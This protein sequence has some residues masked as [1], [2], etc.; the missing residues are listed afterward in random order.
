MRRT[1]ERVQ[2]R[3][4]ANH[5][6]IQCQRLGCDHTVERVT[7]LPNET[8]GAECRFGIDRQQGVSSGIHIVEEFTFELFRERKLTKTYLRCDFPRRGCRD[9][10]LNGFVRDDC[11]SLMTKFFWSECRPEKS[12]RVEKESHSLMPSHPFGRGSQKASPNSNPGVSR[13]PSRFFLGVGSI[14]SNFATGVLSRPEVMM[15]VSPACAFFTRLE[16]FVLASK[17]VCGDHIAL[18]QSANQ[19]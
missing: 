12:L 11:C 7:V 18:P 3:V 14:P 9:K 8:A 15:T 16:R 2:R 1:P 19:S 17:I 10:Q 5:G 4:D 13:T 6:Y